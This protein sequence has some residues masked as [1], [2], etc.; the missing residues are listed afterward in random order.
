MNRIRST[1]TSLGIAVCLGLSWSPAQAEM[2]A[3]E[4]QVVGTW[5]FL[6]HWKK[7]EGPFWLD[8]LPEAS[9]GKLTANAKP[10]TEVGLAGTE[11]MRLL[12]LG[13]YDVV[14]G[15]VP[16]V[17]QDSPA[18]DGIELP[19]LAQDIKT[20]RD[21]LEAYKPIIAREF[22]EKFQAK[23]LMLYAQPSM[24]MFC[25]LGDDVGDDITL[26]DLK[27]KKIR[28]FSAS[29]GDFVEAIGG[30][31]VSIPFAEVVPALEK[32]VVDCGVTG[33]LSAYSAK[34]YQVATHDIRVNLGY[35]SLFIA[36]S[37]DTWNGLGTEAQALIES[38]I[39]KL[40]EE[41]WSAT[42]VDD[43]R[44]MDCLAS[45][46]CDGEPGGMV[47][48]EPTDADKDKLKDV[49]ENVIVRRWANRCGTEKCV[50]DWNETVGK[51]VGFSTSL[52]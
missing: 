13:V 23:L 27:G 40:E 36:M 50:D 3:K 22:E 10:Q 44:G 32:K 26:N 30:T 45:G 8:R 15:A 35:S 47:P 14:H 29:L 31:P 34:W 39:A 6:D 48:V 52:D 11:L 33:T 20:Y 46:P 41:M 5:G 18:I 42:A 38:E 16:Y 17:S 25:N 49:L 24:Q 19:I 28:T 4:F 12:K 43:Q 37:L 2:E 21:V 1:L 7:R 9:N 51:V